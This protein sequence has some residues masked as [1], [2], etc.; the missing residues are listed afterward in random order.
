MAGETCTSEFGESPDPRRRYVWLASPDRSRAEPNRAWD[1]I[2]LR[3]IAVKKFPASL[4]AAGSGARLFGAWERW[5][6]QPH[7]FFLRPGT[8]EFKSGWLTR[9]WVNGFTLLELLRQRRKLSGTECLRLLEPVPAVLDHAAQHDMLTEIDLDKIFVQFPS[10]TEAEWRDCLRRPMEAWPAW[11][12]RVEPLRL[13]NYVPLEEGMT[14]DFVR[15]NQPAEFS[16]AQRTHGFVR[17]LAGGVASRPESALPAFGDAANQLLCHLPTDEEYAT[18]SEFFQALL[19]ASRESKEVPLPPVESQPVRTFSVRAAAANEGSL[20]DNL[21][22]DPINN[23]A[24]IIRLSAGPQFLF[25]R[26]I[27]QVDV[28]TFFHG[29][30]EMLEDRTKG[31]SRIHARA[32][33]LGEEI[34]LF[35]GS[36]TAPSRNGTFSGAGRVSHTEG[37]LLAGCASLQLGAQWRAMLLPVPGPAEKVVFECPLAGVEETS[38]NSR[39]GVLHVSPWPG[40]RVLIETVWLI[41]EA[42]FGVDSGGHLMWDTEAL[43]P[44]PAAFHRRGRRFFFL[45]R[46]IENVEMTVASQPVPPRCGVMLNDGAR[47]QIGAAEW[48][49]R[50]V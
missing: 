13:A 26:A 5:M 21:Y 3:V 40:S 10:A 32:R 8:L 29:A 37:Q 45:N 14:E 30:D 6:T 1:Q 35:D 49:L 19:R 27:D 17:E 20:G 16:A 24:R 36:E 44:G 42:G 15:R 18:A 38:P 34:R 12:I 39:W 9:E 4:S 2:F 43:R 33:L 22:L 41:Q 28:A 48:L 47:L 46:Q 23:A 7:P 25:G 11:T 50:V 31:V